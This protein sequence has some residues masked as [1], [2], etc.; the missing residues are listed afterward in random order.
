MVILMKAVSCR[1][2]DVNNTHCLA[3]SGKPMEIQYYSWWLLQV[4]QITRS[5]MMSN[6]AIYMSKI[7]CNFYQC[8]NVYNT[9]L[10]IGLCKLSANY[11]RSRESLHICDSTVVSHT[12]I[13]YL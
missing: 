2:N 13:I 3:P 8:E 11:Q 7:A 6:P 4:N 10:F 9:S 12:D 1:D 5:H